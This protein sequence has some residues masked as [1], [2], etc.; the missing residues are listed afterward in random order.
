MT[1]KFPDSRIAVFAR[2][3]I[4]GKVK[5]RLLAA[6]GEEGALALYQQMLARIGSCIGAARLAQLDL[7]VTSNPSHESFLTIC[8]KTNIYVQEGD[9]LGEKMAFTCDQTLIG[10]AVQSVLI[11]GTDCPVMDAA[12][13][14]SALTSL[15]AGSD[16]VIGPSE[17]GGYV[18]IGMRRPLPPLF[19]DIPW[20]S[21]RVLAETLSTLEA[22]SINYHLLPTLWDVDIP[23]DLPRLQ[24]L[25]PPLT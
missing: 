23:A 15:Q 1:F 20:G 4:L 2:E 10:E 7:W 12:Y 6:L 19:A 18:L 5:T 13:L 17:D 11:V 16:V 25:D 14:D 22:L 3:P 8:N 21:D 9:D 24:T